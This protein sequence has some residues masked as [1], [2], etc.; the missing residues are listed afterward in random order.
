MLLVA[1]SRTEVA[2][3][4]CPADCSCWRAVL[5]AVISALERSTWL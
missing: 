5:I 3:R 4:V 1:E 2:E